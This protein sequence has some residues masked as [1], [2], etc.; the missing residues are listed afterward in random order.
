MGTVSGEGDNEWEHVINNESVSCL[1]TMN[2]G[3]YTEGRGPASL[4][5]VSACW[6]TADSMQWTSGMA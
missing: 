1:G 2:W 4:F 6:P 3:L 5:I